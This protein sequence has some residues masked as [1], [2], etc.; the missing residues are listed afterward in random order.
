M[1]L[2]GLI[3]TGANCHSLQPI[4]GP[5]SINESAPLQ[6]QAEIQAGFF[7]PLASLLSFKVK[8]Q[9]FLPQT[10]FLHMKDS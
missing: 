10:D 2:T 6:C 5:C 4:L 1:P 3:C 8:V 9:L 7:P